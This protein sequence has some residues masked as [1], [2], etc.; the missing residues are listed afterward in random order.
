M[1]PEDYLKKAGRDNVVRRCFRYGPVC[2]FNVM[3]T[4]KN[5][6]VSLSTSAL[7]RV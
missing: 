3:W 2:G 6:F 5:D 1:R 4:L 7:G